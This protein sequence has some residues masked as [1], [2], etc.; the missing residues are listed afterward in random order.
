MENNHIWREMTKTNN[1]RLFFKVKKN[2]FNQDEEQI[3]IEKPIYKKQNLHIRLHNLFISP[4]LNYAKENNNEHKI[5][6]HLN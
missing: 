5:N 6:T 3:T 2:T 1:D 4:I